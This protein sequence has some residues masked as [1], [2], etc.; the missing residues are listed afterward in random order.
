MGPDGMLPIALQIWAEAKL[1]P[2]IG[3][4]VEERY[5][6]MRQSVRAVVEHSVQSGEL[7]PETDL[8]G[9]TSALY[10]LI[11][12]YALQR[13]LTGAPDRASYMAGVRVLF[14]RG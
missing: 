6:G 8:A 4:I 3:R 14:H 2:A 10:S 11:P 12:G 13:L 1:D 5:S 9:V 7:P